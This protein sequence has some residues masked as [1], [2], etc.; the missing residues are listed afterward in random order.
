MNTISLFGVASCPGIWFQIVLVL[1]ALT[2]VMALPE[3]QRPTLRTRP[4]PVSLPLGCLCGLAAASMM[5]GI[6]QPELLATAFA[7][8]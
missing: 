1:S 5:A 2:M 4:I 8:A 6:M 7:Q 3:M